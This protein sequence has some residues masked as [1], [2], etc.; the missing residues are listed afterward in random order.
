M[1]GRRKCHF[2]K[3]VKGTAVSTPTCDSHHIGWAV[4]LFVGEQVEGLHMKPFPSKQGLHWQDAATRPP[5]SGHDPA[6]LSA[7]AILNIDP[8]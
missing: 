3:A 7:K 2:W 5:A 6:D 1:G 8:V 4:K